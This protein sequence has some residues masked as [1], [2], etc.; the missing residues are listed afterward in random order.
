MTRDEAVAQVQIGIGFRSDLTAKVQFMLLQ[1]QIWAEKLPNLP[2]FLETEYETST[3]AP[4]TTDGGGN[5]IYEERVQLPSNF[6]REKENERLQILR[7]GSDAQGYQDL[8]KRDHAYLQKYYQREVPYDLTDDT[9]GLSYRS[10]AIASLHGVP[11]MYCISKDYWRLFPRPD[12]AYPLRIIF[13]KKDAALS[14]DIENLWLLHYPYLLIG[15]VLVMLGT[16]I[17]NDRAVNIGNTYIGEATELITQ[18]GEQ[19]NTDNSRLAMGM[20]Q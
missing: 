17:G 6:L 1:A 16:P 4:T 19:R 3:T 8:V 18:E 15:R 10:Y 12:A 11:R 14:S 13:Y 5:T 9:T 2:W 7:P 20:D